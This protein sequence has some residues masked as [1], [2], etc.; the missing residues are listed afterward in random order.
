MGRTGAFLQEEIVRVAA[1][2]FGEMG[3]RATSLETVAA[4]VGV[5]KV[6]LYKCVTSK[7][8]LLCRVFDRTIETFRAG[9]RQIVDQPLPA[10]EKLRRIIRYQVTLLAS[11][12]PFLRVFFNEG[13]GLPGPMARRAAQAKRDY[14]RAI[15][16]VVREGI[17]AGQ[18]RNIAPTP[19]VFGV[20]GMC[21]W[22]YKWNR[23][24]GT[25]SADDIASIFIDLLERGYAG[26]VSGNTAVFGSFFPERVIVICPGARSADRVHRLKIRIDPLAIHAEADEVLGELL[27]LPW[28]ID[29]QVPRRASTVFLLSS[30]TPRPA[31][32]PARPR[33]GG[34]RGARQHRRLEVGRSH[35]GASIVTSRGVLDT[36][37]IAC[38]YPGGRRG[39][40]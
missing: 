8:E 12:L 31:K 23:S 19:M 4:E 10:D 1:K 25:L 24:D 39:P 30:T 35:R 9:L 32:F 22:L 26:S 29:D 7:E 33:P 13:S 34:H 21:N 5:S 6:T 14:D 15:E 27:I 2:C 11:H 36:L 20:L 28:R 16:E 3:Y 38:N 37:H 40:P 17:T 18:F